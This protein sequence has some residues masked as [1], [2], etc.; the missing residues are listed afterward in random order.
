M[1]A[2]VAAEM[3]TA[4]ASLSRFC[5][6]SDLSALNASAGAEVA[7]APRLRRMVALARRAQ[8]VTGGRFDPRVVEIL[9]ALGEQ[10]GVPFTGH[11]S[12]SAGDTGWLTRSGRSRLRVAG[13][14]DSGG[15]GKGLGL[16]WAA[17]AAFRASDRATSQSPALEPGFLIEAGGDLVA[18]GG[19]A[20]DGPWRVG[21][22]DPGGGAAPLAVIALRDGALATS[23]TAVRT[24]IAA[25]GRRVHHLIDPRAG[26]PADGGLRSV[27]VAHADPAWAEIWSK[28]LFV[29]GAAAI[30][31]EARA[32][33]MAAWWV[34]DDGSLHLTPAATAMTIWR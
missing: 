15:I 13:A 29:A 11:H 5:P 25:D 24:W 28:A 8:R 2:A 22:E 7:A 3:A 27:T 19:G 26:R 6:D 10:A 14:L 1:W 18:R 23:S 20:G 21:L 34:E 4:D 12:V 31:P 33:G 32:R 17:A 16:R 30:G 9:E